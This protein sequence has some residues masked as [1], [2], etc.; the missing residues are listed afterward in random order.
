MI[1]PP[2]EV[3]FTAFDKR[4]SRIWSTLVVSAHAVSSS[5]QGAV[6]RDAGPWR[7]PAARS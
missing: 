6:R 5:S 4:L 1:F 3:N 7:A 2:A